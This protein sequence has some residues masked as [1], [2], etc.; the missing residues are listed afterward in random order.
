M[1]KRREGFGALAVPCSVFNNT[2]VIFVRH[3]IGVLVL[4]LSSLH[5]CSLISVVG[6]ELVP[7]NEVSLD[8]HLL[9]V[10]RSQEAHLNERPFITSCIDIYCRW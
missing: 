6:L 2:F 9:G 8:Q 5:T 1:A 4:V 3:R 10:H 7:L